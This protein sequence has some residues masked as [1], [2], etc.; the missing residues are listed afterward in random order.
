MHIHVAKT[1]SNKLTFVSMASLM[2][3]EYEA[4]LEYLL[5]AR[6]QKSSVVVDL[7]LQY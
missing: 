2:Q 3:F 1:T 5:C 4:L 6:K 7:P